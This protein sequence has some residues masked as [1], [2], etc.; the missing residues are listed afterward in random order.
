MLCQVERAG[1]GADA[2][3]VANSALPASICA[4]GGGGGKGYDTGH[5]AKKRG[6]A[7]KG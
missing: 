6:E 5:V 7:G 1:D 3:N 4:R 2:R